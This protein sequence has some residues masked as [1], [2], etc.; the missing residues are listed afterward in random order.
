MIWTVVKRCSHNLFPSK[1]LAV[2]H[3][4][5]AAATRLRME[6]YFQFPPSTKHSVTRT[7]LNECVVLYVIRYS[8]VDRSAFW[9]LEFVIETFVHLI[10][11][12][13]HPIKFYAQFRLLQL[14]VC[15]WTIGRF[16]TNFFRACF[17]NTGTQLHA[18]ALGRHR[19]Q[20]FA[21]AP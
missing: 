19:N 13:H 7:A 14:H 8:Q 21:A 16:G 10:T 5:D 2:V 4:E 6:I 11:S 20:R 18:R 1:D 9:A 3:V 15:R 12:Q 17:N